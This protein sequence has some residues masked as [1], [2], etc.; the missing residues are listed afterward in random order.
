MQC[1]KKRGRLLEDGG[2]STGILAPTTQHI[3]T[4]QFYIDGIFKC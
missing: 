3:W 1:C 2:D 4:H